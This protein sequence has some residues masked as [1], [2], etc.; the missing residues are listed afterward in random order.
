MIT[1]VSNE[2]FH[3]KGI[4][5]QFI[6]YTNQKDRMLAIL[7]SQL[8]RGNTLGLYNKLMFSEVQLGDDDD[9]HNSYVIARPDRTK[10]STHTGEVRLNFTRTALGP[11]TTIDTQVILNNIELFLQQLEENNVS[12]QQWSELFSVAL[13]FPLQ[14][15]IDIA[16]VSINRDSVMRK[17]NDIYAL[18]ATV[19]TN[20]NSLV[21]AGQ[22][23][24]NP[25]APINYELDE[26]KRLIYV[27]RNNNIIEAYKDNGEVY[28]NFTFLSNAIEVDYVRIESMVVNPDKTITL[29]GDFKLFYQETNDN[30]SV[31]HDIE[32]QSITIDIHGM[33]V[34]WNPTFKVGHYPL[35]NTMYNLNATQRLYHT[36]M[37]FS[38]NI[39]IF[40]DTANETESIYTTTFKDYSGHPLFAI[41]RFNRLYAACSYFNYTNDGQYHHRLVMARYHEGELDETFTPF[42]IERFDLIDPVEARPEFVSLVYNDTTDEVTFVLSQADT[43][44]NYLRNGNPLIT[45][46][47]IGTINPIY[48][49]DS[50][51]NDI[52]LRPSVLDNIGPYY[53]GLSQANELLIGDNT[54]TIQDN[55]M[56]FGL[57]YR[58]YPKTGYI[59]YYPVRFDKT[60]IPILIDNVVLSYPWIRSVVKC[61]PL[62][63]RLLVLAS[64]GGHPDFD[65]KLVMM[66]VSDD[67]PI[68]LP[69]SPISQDNIDWCIVTL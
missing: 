48:T 31:A 11:N 33:I 29:D 5:M 7:S 40:I 6:D 14:P 4:K 34:G 46:N 24:I 28:P 67:Y 51:G 12:L 17:G 44:V 8:V 20:P 16:S 15:G 32:A 36:P 3:I 58:T 54:L 2:H 37:T 66:I 45:P 23:D 26:T 47:S 35:V 68:Y 19:T 69:H 39:G 53:Y 18:I 49:L 62:G 10:G 13:G 41:D 43:L 42:M 60:G 52:P 1:L 59:G 50:H 9:I 63:N 27:L 30:G 57:F 64:I 61:T 56:F 38:M 21:V 55:G 22:L 25:F 65:G